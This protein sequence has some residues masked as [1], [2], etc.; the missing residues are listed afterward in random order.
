M[1]YNINS[2]NDKHTIVILGDRHARG[3]AK[4]IKDK[5]NK[6]FNVTG[7]MKQEPDILTLTVFAKGV[8]EKVTK[9]NAVVFSEEALKMLGII[10]LKKG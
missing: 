3:C 10:I 1:P 5:I 2:G 4:K 7:S 8:T 6:K 9:N